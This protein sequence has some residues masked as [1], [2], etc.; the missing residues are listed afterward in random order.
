MGTDGKYYFVHTKDNSVFRETYMNISLKNYFQNI[1]SNI[2]ILDEAFYKKNGFTDDDLSTLEKIGIKTSVING[3]ENSDWYAGNARCCNEG[4]FRKKLY[5]E[6]IHDVL[7]FI[8]DNP[9][10]NLSK[11]KS[12]I[13]F[14]LLKTVETNLRGKWR[15]GVTRPEYRDGVSCIVKLLNP[16]WLFDKNNELVCP[17]E[18]S[19]YDLDVSVYGEVDISS[20]IYDILGF[21]KSDK[22]INDKLVSRFKSQFTAQEQEYL[23]KN[24]NIQEEEE[25]F[26]PNIDTEI[27][28]FPE[29]EIKNIDRLKET[30]INT[31]NNAADVEYKPVLRRVRTSRD[32][33]K[34]HIGHRYKGFCQMCKTP[35]SFWEV[36][37]IFNNPK[38]EIEQMNISLCPNCASKYRMLRNDKEKMD[39]FQDFLI[40]SQPEKEAVIPIDDEVE[41]QFTKTHLAEIQVILNLENESPNKEN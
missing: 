27:Q 19:R 31:Y 2:Y 5:F 20:E 7:K 33:D 37:E 9:N 12:N 18:I 15:Y 6:H 25:E 34:E 22:D 23:L 1:G 16:K 30:T 17:S 40:C 28:T 4:N 11:I 29:E 14:S 13:I 24:L 36:A 39:I 35:S 26:D 10:E 41:I 3:M 8:R 32:K 38:K 21:K